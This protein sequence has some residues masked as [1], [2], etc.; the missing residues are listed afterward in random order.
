MFKAISHLDGHFKFK[1]I[2]VLSILFPQLGYR[3][4]LWAAAD[5]QPWGAHHMAT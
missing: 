5:T 1:A 3:L 4:R 2:T